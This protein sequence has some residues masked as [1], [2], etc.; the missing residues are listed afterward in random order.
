M[1]HSPN[2]LVLAGSPRKNGNT[3]RLLK[4]VLEAARLAGANTEVIR[5]QEHNIT[6][7]LGCNACSKTGHCIIKDD[8]THIYPK[9]EAADRLLLASPMY[10]YSMS[11]WLKGAID[12]FQPFWARKYVLKQPRDTEKERWGAFLS[13]GATKGQRLFEGAILTAR[14]TFVDAGFKYFGHLLVGGVDAPGDVERDPENFERA[15]VFGKSFIET[16]E[17]GSRLF[18]DAAPQNHR[19]D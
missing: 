15:A 16:P 8:M 4:P 5:V 9:I 13:V 12:R 11:A 7:C 1:K 2:L 19:K 14:Y 10:F 6:P 18:Q 17:Q 3:D